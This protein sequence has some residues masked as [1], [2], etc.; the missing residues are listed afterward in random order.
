V[1]T[2]CLYGQ[3]FS[4]QICDVIKVMLIPK[5][6]LAKVGNKPVLGWLLLF[7]ITGWAGY[8]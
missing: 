3:C 1:K 6:I 4:F 8:F 2:P 7:F 5:K